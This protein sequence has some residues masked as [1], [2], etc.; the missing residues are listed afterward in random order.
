M[1]RKWE[2]IFR[3]DLKSHLAH[4]GGDTI[5]EISVFGQIINHRK[6]TVIKAKKKKKMAWYVRYLWIDLLFSFSTSCGLSKP[7]T[8]KIVTLSLFCAS[9]F[10]IKSFLWIR[11]SFQI[12][13]LY[14]T[15]SLREMH[16]ALS[17]IYLRI[18]QCNEI[19]SNSAH[20]F[21]IASHLPLHRTHIPD[22]G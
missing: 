13:I 16:L 15:H 21:L 12:H 20:C 1:N 22:L 14:F 19:D 7:E 5:N 17:R 8:L 10:C 3:G 6:L 18:S 2:I 11:N 9:E 4:S